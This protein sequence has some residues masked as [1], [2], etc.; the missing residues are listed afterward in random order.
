MPSEKKRGQ[1]RKGVSKK[2]GQNYFIYFVC[3]ISF[4]GRPRGRMVR[5]RFRRFANRFT[6]PAAPYGSPVALLRRIAASSDSSGLPPPWAGRLLR[7]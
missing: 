2:R 1:R 4:R 5:S 3:W 7:R 6:Q